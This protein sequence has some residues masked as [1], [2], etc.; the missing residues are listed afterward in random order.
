MAGGPGPEGSTMPRGSCRPR[1]RGVSASGPLR[2]KSGRRPAPC[3]P[4]LRS[5]EDH[6]A[7]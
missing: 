6:D 7:Q 5:P 2:T 4:A 1:R 3:C